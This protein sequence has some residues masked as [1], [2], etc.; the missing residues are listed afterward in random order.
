MFK[1]AFLAFLAVVDFPLELRCWLWG[2]FPQ[3]VSGDAIMKLSTN[4]AT[5]I[6][7]AKSRS[8]RTIDMDRGVILEKMTLLSPIAFGYS[9]RFVIGAGE[10]GGHS[11]MWLSPGNRRSELFHL[12]KRGKE[13]NET[14]D[15][16]TDEQA[17][18][19]EGW[20]NGKKSGMDAVDRLT[21]L[22]LQE[23]YRLI[24]DTG[25]SK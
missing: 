24:F 2:I 9:V 16:F 10:A 12:S 3:I 25:V 11:P 4:F 5:K 14:P 13:E 6:Q 1:N 18:K 19:F 15:N 8:S 21:Y 17:E 7:I 20:L 23:L 22:Q